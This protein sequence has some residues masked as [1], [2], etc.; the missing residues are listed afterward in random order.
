M[1]AVAV[2]VMVLLVMMT[3]AAEAINAIS[4]P[5]LLPSDADRSKL[6]SSAGSPGTSGD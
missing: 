5:P 2:I 4:A 1:L 3:P 6:G